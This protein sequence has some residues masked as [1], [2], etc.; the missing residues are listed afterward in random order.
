MFL[1]GVDVSEEIR[2]PRVNHSVSLISAYPAVRELLVGMQ[3]AWVDSN[4]GAAVV[5]GRDI[6]SVVFPEADIKVYLDAAPEVRAERRARDT[7]QGV[8]SVMD[9]HERRDRID[10]T[11]NTSPLQV[12]DGATVIDTSYLEIED[13]IQE[14]VDL[15]RPG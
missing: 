3:R 9:E 10:S 5:E 4:G 8:E 7:G 2:E 14:I 13:V 15:T 12:P 11:R 6:G 1:D